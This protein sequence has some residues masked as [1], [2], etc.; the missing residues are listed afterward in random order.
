MN[1]LRIGK[2]TV[3]DIDLLKTRIITR[4]SKNYPYDACHLFFTNREVNDHNIKMLSRLN[5]KLYEIELV[6]DYPKSYKP[7]ISN[8][9]T[10]DD[11]SLM[12]TLRVKI[13][14]RVMVVLNIS[15]SDSLVNGSLGTIIDIITKDDGKV[16]NKLA[17]CLDVDSTRV[18]WC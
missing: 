18:C 1:R 12:Q 10:V 11:T 5:G 3:E 4:L 16:L 13:G 14:A 17:C 6:G 2:P 9:G 8:F 7:R 15:I